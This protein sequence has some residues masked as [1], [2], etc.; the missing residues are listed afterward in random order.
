MEVNYT[1]IL[2]KVHKNAH[3]MDTGAADYEDGL[4]FG[5]YETCKIIK[6]DGKVFLPRSCT[7]VI[8]YNGPQTDPQQTHESKKSDK[9]P[10]TTKDDNRQ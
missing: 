4:D 2:E 3:N 9:K 1:V 10:S 7:K 5:Q 8:K 6:Q